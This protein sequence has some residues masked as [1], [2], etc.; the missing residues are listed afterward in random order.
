MSS[1]IEK[2]IEVIL[3][4]DIESFLH[5]GNVQHTENGVEYTLPFKFT[6]RNNKYFMTHNK[7]IHKNE[8]LNKLD[9]FLLNSED[10]SQDQREILIEHIN[11]NF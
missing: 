10:F 2:E 3:T 11:D 6:K 8:L 9:D 4:E 1:K 5:S 7:I